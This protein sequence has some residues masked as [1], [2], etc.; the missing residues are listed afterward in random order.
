M[1]FSNTIPLCEQITGPIGKPGD[2]S[3]SA[4][5]SAAPSNTGSKRNSVRDPPSITKKKF[6]VR[7]PPSPTPNKLG[8]VAEALMPIA[9]E[10][11][12]VSTLMAT[13]IM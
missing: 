8:L 7:E 1:K 9:E 3:N 6:S 2:K 11:K 5:S 12:Q 13:R 10:E 4:A